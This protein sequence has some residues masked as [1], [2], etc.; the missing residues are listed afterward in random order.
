MSRTAV[1][2]GTGL[3]V[4]ENVVTNEDIIKR[5]ENVEAGKTKEGEIITGRQMLEG[6]AVR[7]GY[8]NRRKLSK[9]EE[10]KDPDQTTA[11]L[12]VEAGKKALQDAGLKAEDLDLIILSTDSPDFISPPTSAKV[13]YELGAKNAGFF[14]ANAACAGF[15]SVMATAGNFL[16]A[17]ETLKYAMV[18]GGYGMSRYSDPEDMITE[19]MFADGAGA[20]IL[21]AV[22]S[23]AYGIK[24]STLSGDGQ[25]W[26]YMGI[27]AGG[28]WKGFKKDTLDARL[29]YVKF[30]K[31]FP[32]SINIEAW[33]KL[34]EKTL[35]K[36]GWTTKDVD[37]VFFT[38]VNL[39]IINEVCKILGWDPSISHNIMDIYGYTG[40]ACIPMAMD[41]AKKKG[42][43]KKG[44]KIVI[45][46]SGGGAAFASMTMVWGE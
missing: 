19:F 43:L 13:Q 46:T 30:L 7:V 21:K 38:Q 12:C 28:T 2:V 45:C 8:K 24:S 31:G 25:Y 17:D 29:Q 20:V 35:A 42:K 15:T 14:D 11:S 41:D 5:F 26:D 40:S 3:Y 37:K 6:M 22:D 34:I 4:P 23:S 18:I 36:A 44:D 27:Y 39:S 9:L 1:V 10:G 33:P 32:A 16:K